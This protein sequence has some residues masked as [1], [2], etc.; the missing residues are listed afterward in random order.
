L[1]PNTSKTNKSNTFWESENDNTKSS[2]L[3]SKASMMSST[4][5]N[6]K[7]EKKPEGK[8][9]S[10]S[11]NGFWDFEEIGLDGDDDDDKRLDYNSTNL[12]KLSK[13]ELDKH[14]AKM[15]VN[16]L[17]NQK[18]PGDKGFVYDKQEEFDPQE[19]NEWDEDLELDV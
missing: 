5:F 13:A 17:K 1:A 2:S 11:A 6:K 18:K 19:E 15:D 4:G 14:K 16:F 12:N 7:E 9:Q 8:T 10:G 3:G